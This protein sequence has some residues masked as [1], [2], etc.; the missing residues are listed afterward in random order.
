MR[1][2]DAQQDFR[3]AIGLS[4]LLLPVLERV[5]A[6]PQERRELHLT[7]LEAGAEPCDIR[8][9]GMHEVRCVH[10][11]GGFQPPRLDFL[12]LLY[13]LD[14]FVEQ[15]FSHRRKLRYSSATR[16]LRMRSSRGDMSLR[17]FFA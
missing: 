12:H 11:A 14:E 6:D 17:T 7:E 4:P 3:G 16:F 5:D 1:G 8:R 10:N 2:R 15:F 13:A 9:I